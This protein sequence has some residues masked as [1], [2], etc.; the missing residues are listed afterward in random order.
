MTKKLIQNLSA[1]D[2]M[3]KR[4]DAVWETFHNR[5]KFNEP[6]LLDTLVA[7]RSD[8]LYQIKDL[9]MD[10]SIGRRSKLCAPTYGIKGIALTSE[11]ATETETTHVQDS[12]VS[13][14]VQ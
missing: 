7:A 12:T 11:P 4:L 5:F 3:R 1:S 6:R 10:R 9:E 13:G 8:F 14:G 2:F